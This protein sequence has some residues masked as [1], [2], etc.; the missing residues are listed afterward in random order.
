MSTKYAE[1]IVIKIMVGIVLFWMNIERGGGVVYFTAFDGIGLNGTCCDL[2]GRGGD[3][4]GEDP[5]DCGC[6]WLKL[7]RELRGARGRRFL[8]WRAAF[9]SINTVSLLTI[10]DFA[11]NARSHTSS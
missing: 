1:V 6:C 5:C 7:S 10:N 11:A 9:L 2:R 8:L 3:G 4:F